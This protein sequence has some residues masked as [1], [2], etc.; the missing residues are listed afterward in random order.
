MEKIINNLSLKTILLIIFTN[1]L[2]VSIMIYFYLSASN[3]QELK[4]N[5][6]KMITQILD[7]V[8]E[9]KI[10][11]RDYL[12][13]LDE[14]YFNRYEKSIKHLDES[15]KKIEDKNKTLEALFNLINIK[16]IELDHTI[17]L[18]KNNQEKQAL[19][20]VNKNHNKHYMMQ[21]KN[22]VKQYQS[23]L[24]NDLKEIQKSLNLIIFIIFLQVVFQIVFVFILFVIQLKNKKREDEIIEK[25]E[26]LEENTNSYSC[27]YFSLTGKVD[28]S[29]SLLN[30]Y[31]FEDEIEITKE[32]LLTFMDEES[33]KKVRDAIL[34]ETKNRYILKITTAKGNIK[35][36]DEEIVPYLK[37][38]ERVF[39]VTGS[40]VTQKV[41]A[42]NKEKEHQAM[43]L[44][45]QRLAQQGEMLQMIGH[46][47]RQPLSEISLN[48]Q[49]IDAFNP[50]NDEST[51]TKL[52]SIID[53]ADYLTR[54]IADFKNFFSDKKRIDEFSLKNLIDESL[55]V[56]KYRVD[57]L[58][59]K[60][61]TSYEIEN[62]IGYKSE[63]SQ[64]LLA[65]LNNAMDALEDIQEKRE[66]SINSYNLDDENIKIEITDNAGGVSEDIISYV[67]DPYFST[68]EEKN[69]TGLGLYMSKMIIEK[70]FN[71]NVDVSNIQNGACFSIKIPKEIKIKDK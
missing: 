61:N 40:D 11:Q 14:I 34:N 17:F 2:V 71:G 65:I 18:V 38:N 35:Y 16:K 58:E 15:L 50:D 63:L 3:K 21:I 37:G 49:I 43:L 7:D 28:Y 54:T 62:I 23:I 6:S 32:Y 56:V 64:V 46:Q 5:Q 4:N 45:Q 67:F 44:T 39:Y 27:H 53:A 19:D 52:K 55:N 13:T 68:K 66:I 59:I 36:L 20:L 60:F 33:S 9:A 1:L 24:N 70:S 57:K 31:E 10:N 42:Q 12:L 47:W 51:K 69:G 8:K 30:I 22:L 41:L 25:Y 29:K 48:A 26:I